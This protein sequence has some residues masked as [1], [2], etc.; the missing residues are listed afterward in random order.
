MTAVQG[1]VYITHLSDSGVDVF[2]STF[3]VN[4]GQIGLAEVKSQWLFQLMSPSG[5]GGLI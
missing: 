5:L 3:N 4:I 2:Q 1:S